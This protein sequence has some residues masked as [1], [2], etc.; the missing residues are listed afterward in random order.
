[1][2][3]IPNLINKVIFS[4]IAFV[5]F[6][7]VAQACT[8]SGPVR[9]GAGRA[10]TVTVQATGVNQVPATVVRVNLDGTESE[11]FPDENGDTTITDVGQHT[12][13]VSS[14][15]Y[16]GTH[17]IRMKL[18]NDSKCETTT[19]FQYTNPQPSCV[20]VI[21]A[22]G[23]SNEVGW[24]Y[25]LF[26]DPLQNTSADALILQVDAAGDKLVPVGY[27]DQNGVMW[28]GLQHVNKFEGATG[29]GHTLTLA[30]NILRY[31]VPTGCYVVIVPAALGGTTIQLWTAYDQPLYMN[32]IART[33]FAL[34]QATDSALVAIV[35]Q[36]GESNA[37]SYF[38]NPTGAMSPSQ[39]QTAEIG[40]FAQL[41]SDLAYS[42]PIVGGCFTQGWDFDF[43][44]KRAFCTAITNA[45]AASGGVLAG[46]SGTDTDA[47]IGQPK[48]LHMNAY[49]QVQLYGPRAYTAWLGALGITRWQKLP[50][51]TKP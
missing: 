24:G 9:V 47:S 27:T 10:F 50:H 20:R 21:L 35:W 16:V 4:V 39:Y 43:D 1:M 18:A 23:Q 30:R 19:V 28:D 13:T 38:D 22:I 51:I 36:Q 34:A 25:G 15:N 48:G 40:F 5:I 42:G 6:S 31:N 33:R 44:T 29:I 7:T 17:T 12:V 2:F 49:S 8:I 14:T 11:A 45:F 46:Q 32:A 26:T 37:V 41:R 3:K